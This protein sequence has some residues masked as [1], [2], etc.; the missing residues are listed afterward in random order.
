VLGT[1]TAAALVWANSPLAPSY[2]R[3]L[4]PIRHWI[5]DGLMAVFFFAVG[6]EIKREVLVGELAS[7]RRATLP[8]M[9]A[10]GGMVVPALGY[11]LFNAGTPTASG[12][13]VPM[14]TDIAFALGAVAVLGRRVP[15]ALRVFLAAL[16]IA[17]DIGAVLVIAIV[18]TGTLAWLP[19]GAAA[20]L[21]AGLVAANI[22]GVRRESVYIALG[23]ALWVAILHSGVHATV[24]GV[25]LAIT[26]PAPR[27]LVS[28]ERRLRGAVA[29]VI[30]PLFALANAGVRLAVEPAGLLAHPVVL[31]ILVGLVIGKP[32]GITLFAWIAVRSRAAS[33]PTGVT[34]R[35]LHGVA[36]LGGIGFTMSLFIGA[37]AFR[38]PA[39]FALAKL[40]IIGGSLLAAVVGALILQRGVQGDRPR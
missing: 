24:A 39:T 31:G 2:E 15:P 22:A 33:L 36:W 14:A 23:V 12:W 1:A 10:I 37:L 20:A 25:L 9:A 29:F 32:L 3:L 4:E 34:W 8:V 30:L 18:Y 7:R 35:A 40:G 17:D 16:A 19:L 28:L 13:G 38:D 5:N 21:M 6:L 27:P 26:I 11:A